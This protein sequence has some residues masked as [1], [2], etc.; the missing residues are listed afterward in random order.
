MEGQQDLLDGI[1]GLQWVQ[2]QENT[3]GLMSPNSVA[4]YVEVWRNKD[5]YARLPPIK[6]LRPRVAARPKATNCEINP[7]T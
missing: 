6:G 1:R 7:N 5:V 3:D 2:S 4:G